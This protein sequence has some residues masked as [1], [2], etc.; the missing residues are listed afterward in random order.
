MRLFGFF[1]ANR[2]QCQRA[3]NS[4]PICQATITF[5]LRRKKK[6]ARKNAGRRK[7]EPKRLSHQRPT[8]TAAAPEQS[9]HAQPTPAA[10]NSP[11][12]RTAD[13]RDGQ[14]RQ[15]RPSHAEEQAT[16]Q[17]G[18]PKQGRRAT[19]ANAARSKRDPTEDRTSNL[20]RQQ[21]NHNEEQQTQQNTSTAKEKRRA[22]PDD[23]KQAARGT[24]KYRRVS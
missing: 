19:P 21:Q 4:P 5:L 9:R 15:Q 3:A 22:P 10:T 18:T 23:D 1:F 24:R 7:T 6:P 16:E 20:R 2:Y 11:A 17:N 12:D 13:Q 8:A 14:Q